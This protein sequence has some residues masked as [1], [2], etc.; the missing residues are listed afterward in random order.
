MAAVGGHSRH[1]RRR[2]QEPQEHQ[3]RGRVDGG[4][5]TGA[6][7]STGTGGARRLQQLV[8]G[9]RVEQRHVLGAADRQLGQRVVLDHLRYRVE[10]LAELAQDELAA[11]LVLADLHV[12]EAASRPEDSR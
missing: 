4:R 7:A 8:V 5:I 11:A 1:G 10:R 9:H 6:A 2:L 3:A 12:H